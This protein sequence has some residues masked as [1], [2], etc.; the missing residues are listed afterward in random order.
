MITTFAAVNGTHIGTSR[1]H[2][3]SRVVRGM[4]PLG[5]GTKLAP[6]GQA[7][8]RTYYSHLL[9]TGH[10]GL[11]E[12][13]SEIRKASRTTYLAIERYDRHLVDGTVLLHHQED[14]AQAL[15]LDWRDTDVKFQEPDWP[16]D[17]RRATA[18]RIGELLGSI[19]QEGLVK[20]DLALA[21]DGV[22]DHRR[23]SVGPPKAVR[24]CGRASCQRE[25][26]ETT[27]LPP[28]A[29]NTK[30]SRLVVVK[31]IRP[32]ALRLEVLCHRS[33]AGI[34]QHP[35]QV[36]D[37]LGVDVLLTRAGQDLGLI[38]ETD[39]EPVVERFDRANCLKQGQHV[40]PLD[41]VADRVLKELD[42]SVT[43]MAVEPL[44]I[45]SRHGVPFV[46]R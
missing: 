23:M 37:L 44:R 19:F 38:A 16:G 21:I 15:G 33:V 5:T 8:S 20:W 32:P 14:L 25:T 43:V 27:S 24:A 13:R 46:Q 35:A 18:R 1:V 9:F 39:T 28:P 7:G 12:Y 42:E 3:R 36:H 11:S 30:T 17:L 4:V 34:S 2:R 40:V 10:M 26:E 41:V 22:F 29:A 45:C 6:Q 31:H